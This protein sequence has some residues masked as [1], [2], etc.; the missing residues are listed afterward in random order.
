MSSNLGVFLHRSTHVGQHPTAVSPLRKTPKISLSADC[1]PEAEIVHA[2][3]C[4]AGHLNPG[5][6]ASTVSGLSGKF[7]LAHSRGMHPGWTMMPSSS[8]VTHVCAAARRTSL[9]SRLST[10]VLQGSGA[11]KTVVRGP[12]SRRV[13]A[14]MVVGAE[15]EGAIA[16]ARVESGRKEYS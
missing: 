5:E 2:G 6:Y 10:G 3:E 9:E 8:W 16:A 1:G 15:G 14:L 13:M 11:V 4:P 12:R 7:A